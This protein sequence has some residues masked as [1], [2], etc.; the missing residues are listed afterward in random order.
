LLELFFF[1]RRRGGILLVFYLIRKYFI[2]RKKN[3]PEDNPP[4]P[5][6]VS[7]RNF[8]LPGRNEKKNRKEKEVRIFSSEVNECV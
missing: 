7:S 4:P 3:I 6:W 5:K 2:G 1:C 8:E